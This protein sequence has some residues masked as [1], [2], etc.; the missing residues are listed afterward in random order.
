MPVENAGDIE[1][2]FAAEYFLDAGL[3]IVEKLDA[4]LAFHR[5]ILWSGSADA[6]SVQPRKR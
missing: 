6:T 4:V 5:T 2:V 1:A 3:A